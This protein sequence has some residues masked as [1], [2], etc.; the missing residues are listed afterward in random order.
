[1]VIAYQ[2]NG[3]WPFNRAIIRSVNSCIF[4]KRKSSSF[5]ITIF[6]FSLKLSL[7][8]V[9][10]DGKFSNNIFILKSNDEKPNSFKNRVLFFS[11]F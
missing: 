4:I 8:S 7:I 9:K 2:R 1:M 6:Y 5:N 11:Y 3:Q 10:A